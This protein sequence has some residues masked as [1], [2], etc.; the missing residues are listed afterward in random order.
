MRPTEVEASQVSLSIQATSVPGNATSS[1]LTVLG[2]RDLPTFAS[3]SST[4][5]LTPTA[6]AAELPAA[7]GR[8]VDRI[9]LVRPLPGEAELDRLGTVC[10]PARSSR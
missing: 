8:G 4:M 7:H 10:E 9:R 6:D 2:A 3:R 5:R 1:G